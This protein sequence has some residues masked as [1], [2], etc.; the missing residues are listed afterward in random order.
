LATAWTR[1][2]DGIA[3]NPRATAIEG[4]VLDADSKRAKL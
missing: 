4:M 2:E 3:A 1:F